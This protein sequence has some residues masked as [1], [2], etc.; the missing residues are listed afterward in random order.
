MSRNTGIVF[1]L[2]VRCVEST[3]TEEVSYSELVII[4]DSSQGAAATQQP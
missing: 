2:N 3:V 1:F 4:T